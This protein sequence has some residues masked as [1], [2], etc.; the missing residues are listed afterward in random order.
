M[1]KSL[2]ATNFLGESI[3]MVLSEPW[4]TGFLIE[5]IDGLGPAKANINVTEVSGTDGGVYNSARAETKNIVIN[6]RFLENPDIETVRQQSYKY[7]PLKK[8]LTLTVESDYRIASIEGYV[9][10]NEPDIFSDQEGC[11]ISIICPSSFFHSDDQ[12][13]ALS[14]YQQDFEFPFSNESTSQHLIELGEIVDDPYRE[15]YYRGDVDTGIRALVRFK[16]NVSSVTMI[17]DTT[18]EIM[19]IEASAVSSLIG[20][21]FK[22][23]DELVISTVKGDRHITLYRNDNDTYYNI[24]NAVGRNS[25]WIQLYRGKNVMGFMVGGN[26]S[27]VDMKIVYNTLYEG[28]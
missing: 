5:S 9:E 27:D 21:T 28:V 8:K 7:F 20:D 14:G 13:I 19:T 6:F 25:D 17:N 3:K 26:M 1:I 4:T 16:A 23:G 11:Q 22:L 24:I 2:T 15:V 10:S 12:V 18:R